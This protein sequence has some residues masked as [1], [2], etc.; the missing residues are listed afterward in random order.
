MNVL[1]PWVVALSVSD[2]GVLEDPL[3]F[4]YAFEQLVALLV[5]E[6]GVL[7]L[8]VLGGCSLVGDVIELNEVLWEDQGVVKY[9]PEA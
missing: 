9:E 6:R 7:Q 1:Q 3:G 5:E 2:V 4:G 8:L